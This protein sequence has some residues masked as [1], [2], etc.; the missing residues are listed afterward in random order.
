MASLFRR[1][2]ITGRWTIMSP[3]RPLVEQKAPAAR[4]DARDFCPF[5]PGNESN[6][7]PEV[8][9]L[10][11]SGEWNV[12]VVPN[13]FPVLD[14][15]LRPDPSTQGIYD[16]VAGF[17]V[18]EIVIETSDH[19]TDFANLTPENAENV[20]AAWLNR[21][22]AISQDSRIRYIM[23]FRNHGAEAGAT[24]TH[25]HSQLIGLPIVPKL[26]MEEI[27]SSLRYYQWKERCVFCDMIR[28]E[29]SQGVRVINETENFIV[30]APYAARFPYE[31]WLLP[32]SHRAHFQDTTI[33]LRKELAGLLRDAL[34]RIDLV[35]NSPPFNLLLHTTPCQEGETSHY[36]WHIEIMPRLTR[37]A[38]FESGTGF[39]LNPVLPEDAARAL[40]GVRR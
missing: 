33:P 4:A 31:M 39:H 35:L 7:P 5:C 24:L 6:T 11:A 13:R 20:V 36:H 29:I 30:F 10:P 26:V 27:A 9:V 32:K 21:M 28:D 1:D 16:K 19:H 15:S 37:V 12:R 2:P 34:I 40:S 17:G 8:F 22:I 14:P 3:G 38:G 23:L 18:H 25:P